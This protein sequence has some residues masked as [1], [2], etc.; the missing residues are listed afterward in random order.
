MIPLASIYHFQIQKLNAMGDVIACVDNRKLLVIDANKPKAGGVRIIN[1]STGMVG[2]PTV[3]EAGVNVRML[4]DN[5]IE[6]G[7]QVRLESQINP[8]ANGD[9]RVAQI[10]FDIANRH[11][12]F[13]YSLLCSN[14][15]Y[16]QGTN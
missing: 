6:L 4:I 15:V 7:G 16:L 2:V 9:Y 5:S 1:M 10:N 14:L 3:N 12:P 13:W 8:A 11:D